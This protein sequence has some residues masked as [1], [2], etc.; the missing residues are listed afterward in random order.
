ML[1]TLIMNTIGPFIIWKTQK[2]PAVVE[3]ENIDGDLF[4]SERSEEFKTLANSL[5]S[6]GFDPIGSSVLRDTDA[7]TFFRLY[8][9][10]NSRTAATCVCGKNALG[11]V[12]YIEFSQKYSDGSM[13]DVSNNPVPEA[14]PKLD[15]KISYRY[16]S[17]SSAAELFRAF[18][19]LKSSLVQPLTP[20]DY[21]IENGFGDI[22]VFMKRESD[23]LARKGIS[24]PEIDNEGKRS[25]TLYGAI[26]LTY[27][28]VPP[29]KNILNYITERQARKALNRA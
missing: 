13:L 19:K 4:M 29:G 22:E 11:E 26:F 23:A 28:S 18:N 14:Y 9:S 1:N 8:W 2:L 17:I 16:P 10:A 15:L 24:R 20:I 6:L 12:N 3:F 5:E 25:L 21:D 7:D 27:R